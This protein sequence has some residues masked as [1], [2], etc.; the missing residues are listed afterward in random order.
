M[1]NLKKSIDKGSVLS[2]PVKRETY[3]CNFMA[4]QTLDIVIPSYRL[5]EA[6]ILPLLQL[7]KPRDWIVKYYIIV[8]NPLVGISKN[9]A[10]IIDSNNI[11]LLVNTSNEGASA[12][13]NKG[14]EAG[15]GEWVLFLDDDIRAGSDLLLN[16]VEAINKYPDEIGFIGFVSLPPPNTPFATA[17]KISGAT[18]VFDIAEKRSRFTW[19]ATANTLVKR[20]AIGDIRFS[21]AYPKFGGGEDVDFFLHIRDRCAKDFKTV[22]SAK[23]DHPWWDEGRPNFARTLRYGIGNSFLGQFNA[24]YAYYDFL[25]FIETIFLSVFFGGLLFILNVQTFTAVVVCIG[26]IILSELLALWVHLVKREGALPPYI[27]LHVF[28]LR[29]VYQTG[30]LYGNLARGRFRGFGERFDDLGRI[31]KVGFHRFNTYKLV[32]WVAYAVLAFLLLALF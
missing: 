12:S 11:N 4:T 20:S 18:M 5:D 13:R 22:L 26:G 1:A 2:A 24:G 8:D 10:D 32:K 6:Y 7:K 15:V 3:I 23:V 28:F 9:I 30:L 14:L 21:S 16:Y 31:K 19:G 17:L 29:I 27:F 25:N